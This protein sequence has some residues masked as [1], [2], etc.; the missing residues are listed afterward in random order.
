M[1]HVV[2]Q[3]SCP[4]PYCQVVCPVE[5]IIVQRKL[6]Q[7][8]SDACIGC[9]LCRMVC[10]AF[11]EDKTLSGKSKA[12]FMSEPGDSGRLPYKERPKFS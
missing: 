12:W 10:T 6:V 5:A 8:N 9:G 11:S 4:H 3:Q 7:V 2:C 1:L